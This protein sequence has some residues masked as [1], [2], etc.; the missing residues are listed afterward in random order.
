MC[1]EHK[2]LTA[3]QKERAALLPKAPY[4]G[5]AN[6]SDYARFDP[7]TKTWH[8]I[9]SDKP[10]VPYEPSP[11]PPG[12]GRITKQWMPAGSECFRADV[13]F[14]G[15]R[16]VGGHGHYNQYGVDW[17]PAVIGQKEDRM[18][19]LAKTVREALSREIAGVAWVFLTIPHT[20]VGER[21]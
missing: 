8:P 15:D 18:A 20:V 6:P 13:A 2:P 11:W 9:E 14:Y 4:L 12:A 16:S 7:S 5:T 1:A 3:D 21:F 17:D 19:L 10:F